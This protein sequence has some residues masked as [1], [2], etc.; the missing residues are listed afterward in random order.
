VAVATVQ[1]TASADAVPDRVEVVV[2]LEVVAPRADEALDELARRSGR[3]DAVLDGAGDAVLVRRPSAVTLV[4]RYEYERDRRV[5]RGQ[6][7]ARTLSVE[8]RPGPAIGEVLRRSVA[9]AQARVHALTWHVDEDNPVH[10]AVRGAA[11]RNARGRAE[12]YAAELDLR[13]GP[14]EWLAEPGL[15]GDPQP[16]GQ[17]M[18][19]GA[20]RAFMAVRSAVE[21]AAVEG[22]E[23]Q[24]VLDLAPQPVRVDAAIQA[25]F[26]LLPE[27]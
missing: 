18:A 7:A 4:P 17:E 20:P 23:G 2:A 22:G 25:R 5:F 13:L 3:F 24:V 26:T 1:G 14:V 6:V 19:A 8:L 16:P 27:A 10:V 12:A 21:A 11:A 9:D 15:A